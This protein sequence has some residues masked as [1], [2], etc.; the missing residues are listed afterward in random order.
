MSQRADFLYHTGD[1]KAPAFLRKC[2][3]NGLPI[4]C[5]IITASFGLLAF[6][7]CGSS[8]ATVFN[9][10]YALSS[11]TGLVRTS[12]RRSVFYVP[13]FSWGA[14]YMVDDPALVSEVLRGMQSAG[15]RP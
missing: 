8:A 3:K 10:L 4:Y 7:S 15:Y 2:T 9:D 6:M 14:D 12:F 11:I 1:G 13:E 5:L